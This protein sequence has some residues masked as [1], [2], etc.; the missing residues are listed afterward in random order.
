MNDNRCLKL[1]QST[2]MLII[3]IL[4]YKLLKPIDNDYHYQFNCQIATFG[5]KGLILL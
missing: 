1:C 5:L 4:I 3:I 2:I